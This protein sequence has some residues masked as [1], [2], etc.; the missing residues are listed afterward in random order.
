MVQDYFSQIGF[1]SAVLA[2]FAF[3]FLG[4]QLT[5]PSTSK[6]FYWLFGF[7]L[8]AALTLV[9][10]A[11]GSVFG[12]LSLKSTTFTGDESLKLQYFV[13][14]YFLF[15]IHFLFFSAGLTGFLHSK[16]LGIIGASITGFCLLVL[17][18]LIFPF[19]KIA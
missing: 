19:V 12:A 15:G 11:V 13:S 1:I 18:F 3:T 2:G 5:S 16:K 17:W 7:S 4:S 9:L 8:L 6:V 10:S 14:Q